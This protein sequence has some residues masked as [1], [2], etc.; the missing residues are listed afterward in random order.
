MWKLVLK[1]AVIV[2]SAAV[3]IATTAERARKA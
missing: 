2:L 3:E 1:I